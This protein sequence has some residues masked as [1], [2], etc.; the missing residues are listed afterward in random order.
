[1]CLFF[2]SVL[3]PHS[4][5]ALSFSLSFTNFYYHSNLLSL[6]KFRV[7]N[8]PAELISNSFSRK[9][10]VT[11]IHSVNRRPMATIR[12]SLLKSSTISVRADCASNSVLYTLCCSMCLRDLVNVIRLRA[13]NLLVRGNPLFDHSPVHSDL[14]RPCTNRWPYRRPPLQL[15]TRTKSSFSKIQSPNKEHFSSDFSTPFCFLVLFL[16]RF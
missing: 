2:F 16:L 10:R 14:P 1:M 6:W 4:L 3:S 8:R 5:S 13:R 9:L 11:A 15:I 12:V 7:S